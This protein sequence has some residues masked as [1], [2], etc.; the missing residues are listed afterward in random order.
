MPT[1]FDPLQIGDITLPN[2]IIMAPLT[3]QRAE[4]IR[5][6]NALMARY[7]AERASAGLI[8]SEATSVTPQGVGYAETPGIWSQEQVEGWKLVTQAVH[9]AGGKIFLQLWHVGRISDP[10]FLNGELPV[11]PSAIAAGG[12]V[13]LVRPER[14]FVTPRALGLDEIAGVVEAFRK[15]AENAKAAGFDGVEVHGAN[16]YLLDQFLQ[17]S[18]NKRTDTYARPDRKPRASAARSHR[19]VHQR[20]GCKPRRRASRAAPRRAHDGRF[21]SGRNVR[22]CRARTRQAQDRV[23]RGT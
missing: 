6:P 21:R 15:G 4:E 3:R 18:T 13:S 8:L 19:R 14:P 9:D 20:V 22:L 17:D 2:R 23:Y 11:A 10:L 7:Y 16:G 12:H 5:V 1:L